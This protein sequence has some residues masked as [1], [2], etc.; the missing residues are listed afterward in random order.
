MRIDLI[1]F[2]RA[3]ALGAAG[4]L[5][6]TAAF[7]A[8]GGR[9]ADAQARY[10]QERAACLS[11]QSHQD[12]STCLREAGAALEEARRGRLDTGQA[13][14]YQENALLRCSVLPSEERSACHARMQGQGTT[15]GSVA[16]G[17][18]YR[19]L[20]IREVPSDSRPAQ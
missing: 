16:E 8:D 4:A 1:R 14:R 13:A 7:A 11:G 18:I 9:P 15:R 6:A 19:E 2:G 20:I 3:L 12:Q 10:Q 5:S 17:G